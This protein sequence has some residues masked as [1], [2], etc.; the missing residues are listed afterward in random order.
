MALRF[1]GPETLPEGWTESGEI[2][3]DLGSKAECAERNGERNVEWKGPWLTD[4]AGGKRGHQQVETRRGSGP[5]CIQFPN[6]DEG[7]AGMRILA[8]SSPGRLTPRNAP[9]VVQAEVDRPGAQA[10]TSCPSERI[11]RWPQ[12]RAFHAVPTGAAGLHSCAMFARLLR[13]PSACSTVSPA[14]C[15]K[16][17]KERPGMGV[18]Q[19]WE[20]GI[21]PK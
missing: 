4:R 2:V 1:H 8:H 20:V 17:R 15:L 7:C 3:N 14:I 12:W 16:R 6:R 21:L 18:A 5:S 9:L 19:P 13:K 11:L 10:G